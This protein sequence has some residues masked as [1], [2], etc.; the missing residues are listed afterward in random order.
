MTIKELYDW[1]IENEVEDVDLLIR[2]C[3]GSYTYFVEPI[4]ILRTCVNGTTYKEVELC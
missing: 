2:D 3:D 1:A 4:V